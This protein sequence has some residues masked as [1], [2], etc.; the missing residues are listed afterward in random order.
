LA[1]DFGGLVSDN[2]VM[3][4]HEGTEAGRG[5]RTDDL[6]SAL[7]GRTERRALMSSRPS[8]HGAVRELTE[9]ILAETGRK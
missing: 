9:L 4:L 2:P 1:L 8:G 3:T 7:A 5:A 6:A